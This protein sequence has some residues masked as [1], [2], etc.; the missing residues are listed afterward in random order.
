MRPIFPDIASRGRM[1]ASIEL[2]AF[3]SFGAVNDSELISY[4]GV[5]SKVAKA[6]ALPLESIS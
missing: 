4:E 2:G 3:G 5:P 6:L 1:P